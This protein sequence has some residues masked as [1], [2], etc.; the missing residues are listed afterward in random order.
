[1]KIKSSSTFEYQGTS[2]PA[3]PLSIW[4]FDLPRTAVVR[5]SV[6]EPGP[7]ERGTTTTTITATHEETKP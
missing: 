6:H 4:L 3:G 1:M 2:T 7:G 5:I